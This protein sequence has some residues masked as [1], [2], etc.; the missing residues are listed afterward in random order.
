[1]HYRLFRPS[2]TSTLARHGLAR[3]GFL[4]SC[5]R[6][7]YKMM[8]STQSL[9]EIQRR[10]DEVTQFLLTTLS[11][12]NAHTVEFF[13][14]DVW[15]RFVAVPPQEVLTAFSSSCDQQRDP[16]LK[17]KGTLVLLFFSNESEIHESGSQLT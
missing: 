4:W 10:I 7:V 14:H 2:R 17:A 1:M 13:T 5:F 3:R 9:S 11:I 8:S 15:S 16:E 12:A 6:A